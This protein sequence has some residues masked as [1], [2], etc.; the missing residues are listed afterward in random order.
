M[1]RLRSTYRVNYLK[2]ILVEL[3]GGHGEALR[4][5][6][7]TI[8]PTLLKGLQVL[9]LHVRLDLQP[10]FMIFRVEIFHSNGDDVVLC[11]LETS[12]YFRHWAREGRSVIKT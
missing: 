4:L 6:G 11:D 5:P 1:L 3:E 7:C 10:L 12:G 2:L 8:V 9:V